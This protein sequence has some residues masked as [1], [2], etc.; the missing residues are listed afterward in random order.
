M[1]RRGRCRSRSQGL[2]DFQG[3]YEE[4]LEKHP[5]PEREKAGAY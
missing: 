3:T 2:I 4:Y 5:L 1:R